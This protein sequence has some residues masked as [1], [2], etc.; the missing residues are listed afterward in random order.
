L[1]NEVSSAHPVKTLFSAQAVLAAV[2]ASGSLTAGAQ[3]KS[4]DPHAPSASVDGVA[5]AIDPNKY[6]IGPEDILFIKVWREPDFTIP[7]AVRPDGKITMP[8]IGE[9]Q[10]AEQ[11]PLQLTQNLAG[12]LTKYINNPDVT[13]FVTEV[14]SKKYYI[15]GEVNRP[16][17]FPLVT[18]TTVLE[19]LSRSGGFKDFA[20]E[21]KIR[22][23]RAGKIHFFNFKEVTNGKHLEQNIPVENGDHII[24]P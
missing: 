12:L 7:V 2:I 8:L 21:K 24:V 17:L 13:V 4:D 1:Y 10:A 15:D 19:A 5:A 20:N 6:R 11:T 3:S 14:R 16:G 18:P 23:L 22:I 9:I